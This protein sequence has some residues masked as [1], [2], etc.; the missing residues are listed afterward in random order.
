MKKRRN[1]RGQALIEVGIS[2]TLFLAIA[3][4]LLTFGHVEKEEE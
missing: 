3:L 2:I 4:G 1:Q